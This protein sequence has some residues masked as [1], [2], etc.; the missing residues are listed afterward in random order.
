MHQSFVLAANPEHGRPNPI[1]VT[2][3]DCGRAP[4]PKD[5]LEKPVTL[6]ASG[7]FGGRWQGP[8]YDEMAREKG[9][10]LIG[11]D[12]PGIGGTDSVPLKHRI[13]TW[14]DIVPALLKHLDITCVSLASHSSGSM[15]MLSTML[16]LRHLLHPERPYAAFIAPW[17]PPEFSGKLGMQ[18]ASLMPSSMVGSWHKLAEFYINYGLPVTGGVRSGISGLKWLGSLSG[19]SSGQSPQTSADTA[20]K[21]AAAKEQLDQIKQR[22]ITT[23]LFAEEF[24]GAS[25]EALL[26]MGKDD[27]AWDGIKPVTA[28]IIASEVITRSQTPP[29]PPTKLQVS[30]FLAEND[31]MIGKKGN[32]Y[33]FDCL[34]PGIDE[35]VL[36]VDRFHLL[37]CDHND[38]LSPNVGVVEELFD[39]ICG[40]TRGAADGQSVEVSLERKDTKKDKKDTK[41]SATR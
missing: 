5:G 4:E 27:S 8:S 40:Q 30:L 15:F 10:R 16:H 1:R 26:C 32:Q 36:K 37:G 22:L 35:G 23:Y 39:Q 3:S 2:F 29:T 38:V 31:E 18:F 17:V 20:G 11:V 25:Q 14:L 24:T 19:L 34:K 13:T 6:Y 41:D 9:I 7:M 21:D 33:W 28:K 12:R